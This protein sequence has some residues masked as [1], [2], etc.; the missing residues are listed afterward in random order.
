M[1]FEFQPWQRLSEEVT[2][3]EAD[4][5]ARVEED[6]W[7]FRRCG[8]WW[9]SR[10]ASAVGAEGNLVFRPVLAVSTSGGVA[11]PDAQTPTVHL[12]N[13]LNNVESDEFAEAC[14]RVWNCE[15]WGVAWNKFKGW[16][17]RV[18]STLGDWR[19]LFPFRC[20]TPRPIS[21]MTGAQVLDELSRQWQ[22]PDSEFRFCAAFAQ[23]S[24]EE[25]VLW[26]VETRLSEPAHMA[27]LLRAA[28]RSFS[29]LWPASATEGV[30]G[31]TLHPV[32]NRF[33]WNEEVSWQNDGASLSHSSLPI[34]ER[35]LLKRVVA[36]FEPRQIRDSSRL[37][38]CVQQS[39]RS[40]ATSLQF[41]S[42]ALLIS[43]SRPTQHERLE[44]ALEVRDWLETHWPDGVKHLEKVV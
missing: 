1:D 8:D 4:F 22:N 5:R 31:F 9:F 30:L 26:K 21:Q 32:T 13:W 20:D 35:V 36:L 3:G 15:S 27:R 6:E 41:P 37:P 7:L 28:L 16:I 19:P 25:R 18:D 43:A 34:R 33:S 17:F 2:D 23:L 14:Y 42:S 12:E 10:R 39:Q 40:Y 38:M 44:A 11:L 29:A 24:V